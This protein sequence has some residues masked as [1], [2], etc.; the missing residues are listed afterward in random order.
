M[1]KEKCAE[2]EKEKIPLET[3]VTVDGK[4]SIADGDGAPVGERGGTPPVGLLA[5]TYSRALLHWKHCQAGRA[6]RLGCPYWG[7]LGSYGKK[8]PR[9]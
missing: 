8:A 6:Q 9:L 1:G 5:G 4:L 2:K 3:E 7:K